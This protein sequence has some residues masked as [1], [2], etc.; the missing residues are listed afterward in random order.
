MPVLTTTYTGSQNGYDNS[1]QRTG[2]PQWALNPGNVQRTINDLIYLANHTVGLLDI[3]E[4][5][6]ESAGFISPQWTGTTRQFFQDAYYAIRSV[7]GPNLNIMIG[8]AFQG[9]QSWNGFLTAGTG[10]NGVLMDWVRCI[11][12][13]ESVL[14][15]RAAP[16]PNL[17]RY[18]AGLHDRPA[19][20]RASSLPTSS[21]PLWL[22]LAYK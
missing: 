18:T 7:I 10:A 6:N 1:G 13:D 9:V 3:L 12:S 2:N 21:Q 8:D 19:Y 22:T 16:V 11:H 14:I 4:L 5:L 17:Q 20:I 15:R